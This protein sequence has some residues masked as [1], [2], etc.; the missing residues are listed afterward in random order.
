M[1]DERPTWP[2]LEKLR[3]PR[4]RWLR[5]PLGV[6]LVVGGVFGFLPL[7]GFWMIPLGLSILALDF[8]AAAKANRMIEQFCRNL[9]ERFR[10]RRDGGDA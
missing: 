5:I 9:I 7:V 2:W 1:M 8:P 3:D 4:T 6:V 10:R